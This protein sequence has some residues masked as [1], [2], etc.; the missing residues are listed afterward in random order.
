MNM[1]KALVTFTLGFLLG[2]GVAVIGYGVHKHID[3]ASKARHLKDRAFVK[4]DRVFGGRARAARLE[5]I[6]P[7]APYFPAGAIWTQDISHAPLDPP[8]SSTIIAWLCTDAGGWGNNDK[9]CKSTLWHPCVTS[10]RQFIRRF[11]FLP[12]V[13]SIRFR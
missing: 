12:R 10:R 6:V 4:L 1:I 3:L 7:P 13:S 11:A 5:H 9:M 8:V 2:I